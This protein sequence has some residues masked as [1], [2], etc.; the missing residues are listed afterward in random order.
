IYYWPRSGEN[1]QAASVIAPYLETLVRMEGTIDRPVINIFFKGISFQHTG[2][3]R[4]SYYGHVPHQAGMYM[5]EAY[6]LRPAGTKENPRLDN[7][8]WIGRPAAAVEICF[9]DKTVFENCRFEHLASTGLDYHKAVHNNS[10]IANLF[11]D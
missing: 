2:W 7:Q 3:L 6:K 1:M 5:T 10:V 4:P 8:A 9:A 11:K